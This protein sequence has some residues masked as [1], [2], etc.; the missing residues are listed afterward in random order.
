[1]ANYKMRLADGISK[2]GRFILPG[3]KFDEQES[4]PSPASLFSEQ[5]RRIATKVP[6]IIFD[7]V[8]DALACHRD[9]GGHFSH[10]TM[11]HRAIPPHGQMWAEFRSSAADGEPRLFGA[12]IDKAEQGDVNS[13]EYFAAVP[14]AK[15][16]VRYLM[17]YSWTFR[18]FYLWSSI[19]QAAYYYN[20]IGMYIGLITGVDRKRDVF[21]GDGDYT[22]EQ[23]REFILQWVCPFVYGLSLMNHKSYQGR[24]LK[25][26][27]GDEIRVMQEYGKPLLSYKTLWVDCFNSLKSSGGSEMP[28]RDFH[29]ARRHLVAGHFKHYSE[30]RPLFGRPGNNGWF[31]HDAHVR[32]NANRGIVVKDYAIAAG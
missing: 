6:R 31:W 29:D 10:H 19:G 4:L 30:D 25:R 3:H 32:G 16:C 12:V 20:D 24:K 9:S 11:T 13:A 1:M 27:H 22:D 21:P 7:D 2:A 28:E 23:N 5:I 8:H 26:G 18:G 14:E 17:F 15:W